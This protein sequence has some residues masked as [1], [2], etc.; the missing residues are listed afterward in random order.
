[1]TDRL[2][3]SARSDM[4]FYSKPIN[5]GEEH[6]RY[7]LKLWA[8]LGGPCPETHSEWVIEHGG[9]RPDE[10]GLSAVWRIL[11][12]KHDC[13]IVHDQFYGAQFSN[14]AS[15]EEAALFKLKYL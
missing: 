13:T 10:D 11:G 1:M 7:L 3:P 12:E 2:P 14:F 4:T 6:F 8:Q 9:F 5:R 15:D